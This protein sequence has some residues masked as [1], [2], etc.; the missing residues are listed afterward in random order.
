MKRVLV[1]TSALV[2][3]IAGG[4]VS[5]ASSSGFIYTAN[6]RDGSISEIALATGRVRTFK[7]AVVPHNVQITPDNAYL[8][9]VGMPSTHGVENVPGTPHSKRGAA[10][11]THDTRPDDG[12]GNL[13]IF[14]VRDL[15]TLIDLEHVTD[16]C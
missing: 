3:M 1:C 13:L 15:F 9:V 6:E 7:V 8:L 10:Q 4:I 16:L 12:E 5:A 14:D 2:L 11:P